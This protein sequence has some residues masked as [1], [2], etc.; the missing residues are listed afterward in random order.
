MRPQKEGRKRGGQKYGGRNLNSVKEE[1]DRCFY[2]V[3]VHSF[4]A[5]ST[6]TTAQGTF[7]AKGD[8]V[9]PVP[10]KVAHFL[11]RNL[12]RRCSSLSVLTCLFLLTLNIHQA[13]S[14]PAYI[15]S[16]SVLQMH[17]HR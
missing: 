12:S 4:R 11:S 2:R 10:T 16:T 5:A 3:L 8:S 14:T 6:D 1:D 13:E 9:S 17:E 7:E 15:S